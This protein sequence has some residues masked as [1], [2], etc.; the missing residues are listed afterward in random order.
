MKYK[1]IS[2]EPY[3][4]KVEY[5]DGSWAQVPVNP[6]LSLEEID[7]EVSKYDPDF[8]HPQNNFINKNISV[9]VERE[10]VK[11][12]N[13]DV[14]N[15]ID[16]NVID[17]NVPQIQTNPTNQNSLPATVTFRNNQR[18][19]FKF[20]GESPIEVLALGY[21]FAEKGD[22]RIKDALNKKIE[23]FINSPNFSIEKIVNNLTENSEDIYTQALAELESEELSNG[24]E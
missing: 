2:V 21:Y 10:S 12:E 23:E 11:I 13:N 6:D 1:V 5:E 17:T 7:N 9:G 14:N 8:L 24:N 22:T 15:V 4:M 18:L 20:N 3:L 19:E 16:T